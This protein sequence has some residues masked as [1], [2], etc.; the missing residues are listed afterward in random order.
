MT[1]YRYRVRNHILEFNTNSKFEVSIN[2]KSVMKIENL[3]G[4]GIEG[5]FIDGEKGC[6]DSIYSIATLW[7]GTSY[8]IHMM[9]S[10]MIRWDFWNEPK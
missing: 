6:S 9:D 5:T 7:D 1:V 4:L 8:A 2:P 10:W 3:V